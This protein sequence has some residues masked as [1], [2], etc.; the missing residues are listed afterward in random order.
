M[1]FEEAVSKGIAKCLVKADVKNAHNSFPKDHAQRRTIEAAHADPRL[2]PL[3][4]AGD[5]ILRLSTPIYMRDFTSPKKF[6]FLCEGL[7]GG[8]Q[9]LLVN[10]TSSIR[11]LH[12]KL[13]S[14]SSRM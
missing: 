13:F 2:I 9:L 14:R 7:M 8:G 3:A 5:S 11:T 6:N 10:S 1:R 4:V 12:S